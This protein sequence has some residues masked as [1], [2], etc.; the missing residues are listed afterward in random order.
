[1]NAR[2]ISPTHMSTNRENVVKIGPVH[3]DIGLHVTVLQE[4][5]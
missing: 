4:D 5:R 1:M 3:F 2:M